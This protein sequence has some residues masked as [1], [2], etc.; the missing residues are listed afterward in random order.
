MA[1]S[2]SPSVPVSWGELL[3]KIT[4]LEIKCARIARPGARANVA[5][6]YALLRDIAADA[7]RRPGMTELLEE[8]KAVNEDLWDIED[9]IREK[10]VQAQFGSEFI[11]LARSV[12]K[13]NDRRAALKR[14]INLRLGSDLIEEKSYKAN[15]PSPCADDPSTALIRG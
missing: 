6:E 10:E 11:S 3:D 15:N 2:A 12:Y 1:T 4:I 8:L 13:R 5:R 14:A 9:E 7:M